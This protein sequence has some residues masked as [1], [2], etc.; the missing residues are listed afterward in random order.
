MLGGVVTL[1]KQIDRVRVS[2]LLNPN[3]RQVLQSIVIA[4]EDRESLLQ[5]CL[6]VGNLTG[7]QL[8]VAYLTKN[9]R[10]VF[11]LVRRVLRPVLATE[12]LDRRRRRREVQPSGPIGLRGLE[13]K[14]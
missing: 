8:Q 12:L 2:L 10:P 1:L 13:V 9:P 14:R 7:G 6:G 4:G 3:F 11:G 5:A